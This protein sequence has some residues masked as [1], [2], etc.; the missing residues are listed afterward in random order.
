[1]WRIPLG[2]PF[3]HSWDTDIGRNKIVTFTCQG[4]RA[5]G[6]T[7]EIGQRLAEPPMREFGEAPGVECVANMRKLPADCWIVSLM[8]TPQNHTDLTQIV[9]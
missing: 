9:L 8:S 2:F 4:M 3:D 7:V 5:V 6:L 1:M